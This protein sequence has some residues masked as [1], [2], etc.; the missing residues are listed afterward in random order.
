MSL[1]ATL[2]GLLGSLVSSRC[3][4]DVIPDNPTFPLIVYQQVGG[5]AVDFMDQTA[6]DK[7]NV[8]VQVWVWSKTRAEASSIARLARAAILGS[9][10]QAKTLAAPVSTFEEPMKLYGSRTDFSIWFVP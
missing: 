3:Y 6:A 4:P 9:T 8:R 2:N 10:L 7:E 5:V 1:E